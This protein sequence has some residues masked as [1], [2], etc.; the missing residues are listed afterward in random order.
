M[1]KTR[2]EWLKELEEESRLFKSVTKGRV[3]FAEVDSY[4]VVHNLQYFFWL[5]EARIEYFR[6][7]GVGLN[8]DSLINELLFMSVHAE[9]DYF[10]AAVFNDEF[11]VLTRIS[12]IR[13]S[14]FSFRNIIRLK[15][16]L[17]LASASATLAHVDPV[18][19]TPKRISDE[20]RLKVQ[21]FEGG[22][23]VI[24]VEC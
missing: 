1:N 18:K 11:E 22:N 14:S 10:N 12:E 13:N 9:L 17:I 23:V 3:K 6:N 7:L 2:E 15:N 4:R 5:E 24:S 19:K 21:N 8:P 20:L 16:G